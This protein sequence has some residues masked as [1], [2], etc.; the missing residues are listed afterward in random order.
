MKSNPLRARLH[1]WALPF[2]FIYFWLMFRHKHVVQRFFLFIQHL[3]VFHPKTCKHGLSTCKTLNMLTLNLVMQIRVGSPE[4][5]TVMCSNDGLLSNTARGRKAHCP[6]LSSRYEWNATRM[7]RGAASLS[8]NGWV[9]R[10]VGLFSTL[11]FKLM[12]PALK[13]KRRAVRLARRTN[14]FIPEII[15][16]KKKNKT[17]GGSGAEYVIS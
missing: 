16:I 14:T 6:G 8:V 12:S 11:T 2:L 1:I 13:P 9:R 15:I 7:S 10:N 4:S 3:L 5:C 17:H